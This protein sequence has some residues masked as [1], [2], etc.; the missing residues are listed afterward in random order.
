M[1]RFT[2]WAIFRSLEI[3][4]KA[5]NLVS[6]VP[7]LE[8]EC[9]LHL[10]ERKKNLKSTILLKIYTDIPRILLMWVPAIPE[11][12]RIAWVVLEFYII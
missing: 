10:N 3:S 8:N 9:R 6:K 2:P 1:E 5:Y 4:S 7:K 11:A 12:V